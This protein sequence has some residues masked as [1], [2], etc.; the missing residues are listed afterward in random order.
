MNIEN[1]DLIDGML[2]VPQEDGST[3]CIPE[4]DCTADEAVLFAAWRELYP[5]GKPIVIDVEAIKLQQI[6]QASLYC[7]E[8]IYAGFESSCLGEV[9][10]FDCEDTDQQNI[11]ALALVA[12]MGLQGLTAS[13]THWKCTGELECYK[14]EYA[15]VLQLAMDMKAHVQTQ[16]DQFNAERIAI[17][18]Q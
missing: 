17:L 14:F 1:I 6:Q 13:E 8:R 4:E 12:I 15:Q 7:R 11:T 5:D 18:A 10:H 2:I 9:K 16:L 3:L